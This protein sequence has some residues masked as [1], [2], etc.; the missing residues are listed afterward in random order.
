M[1]FLWTFSRRSGAVK[2]TSRGPPS[3]GGITSFKNTMHAHKGR[4]EDGRRI[5]KKK[6][7][8]RRRR[9][10]NTVAA[11]RTC[12]QLGGRLVAVGGRPRALRRLLFA[13]IN[14]PSPNNNRS[15]LPQKLRWNLLFFGLLW[16]R[17]PIPPLHDFVLLPVSAWRSFSVMVIF[18]SLLLLPSSSLSSLLEY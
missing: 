4:L 16:F 10:E 7:L 15:R 3:P 9:G 17:R 13:A 12:Y 18:K 14:H 2:I 5:W 6:L 1:G 11:A 8:V